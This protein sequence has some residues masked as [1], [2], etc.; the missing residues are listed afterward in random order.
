M[1]G[2]A[3]ELDAGICI[4]R[5]R[6][7]FTKIELTLLVGICGAMSR[8]GDNEPIYLGD[9]IVGTEVWRYLH[10]ARGSR[11]HN[12]GVDLD[13]RNYSAGDSCQRVKQLGK[14]L[15]TAQFRQQTIHCSFG[16]LKN[17][18]KGQKGAKFKYPGCEMDKLFRADYVHQH[19]SSPRSCKCDCQHGSSCDEAKRTPCDRLGCIYDKIE[20]VRAATEQP[21]KPNIHVGTMA[22]ADI[23]MRASPEFVTQLKDRNVLG[24]DMEGG[25]VYRATD[26]IVIKG[27]VDYADTHKNKIFADYAAASAASV[28]LAFLMKLY[29]GNKIRQP[30]KQP[31]SII[32]MSEMNITEAI[33]L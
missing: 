29:P 20:R 3:G 30:Q 22:S 27:V 1:P 6:Q 16:L 9:V 2:D 32:I 4:Q 26:C 13:L 28:A 8:N 19:R 5:L 24:I 11:L 18:Q 12:G 17:L 15:Q 21:P 31:S 33:E 14:V 23:V 10:N 7:H 25:G